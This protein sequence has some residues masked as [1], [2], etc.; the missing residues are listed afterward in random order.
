MLA[1]QWERERDRWLRVHPEPWNA[2][3]EREYNERFSGAIERWLDTGHGACL[4]RQ[5]EC[6]EIVAR[7]LRHF[8]GERV[9]MIS[10]VVMPNHV[11]ALFGQ[12][13]EWSLEKLVHSWKRF[14]TRQSIVVR[15]FG[16]S[17]SATTSIVSCATKGISRT[18]CAH[19]AQ[20]GEGAIA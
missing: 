14:A 5:R 19:S 4:L 20:S 6:A 3:I 9:V 13:P 11:H 10:S 15:P 16:R 12:N 1:Q 17:G 8:E 7:T 18:A 2:E